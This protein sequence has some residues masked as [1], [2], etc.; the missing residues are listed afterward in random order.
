MLPQLNLVFYVLAL[1]VSIGFAFF[2]QW[3]IALASF[4]VALA[5]SAHLRI[6]QDRS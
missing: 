2:E 1:A 6:A 4:A 3:D 5:L